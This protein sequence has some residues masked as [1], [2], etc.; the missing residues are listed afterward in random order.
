MT[1][2]VVWSVEEAI[3]AFDEHLRRV[4]GL[5]A[6]T[7]VNYARFAGAFLNGRF[8]AGGVEV[9][10]IS[11]GDVVGFVE[12]STQ[13]YQPR[14]VELAATSL[15]SL[16]RFFRS[17]GRCGVELEM[18]VPMVPHRRR[19][20]VRHLGGDEVER[21]IASL[22]ASSTRGLRDR[23]VILCVARLG[24]R[25]GEVAALRLE[26]IEWRRATVRVRAR[27]TGHGARLPLTA[28][29]GEALVDYL[30]RGRP[31]TTT[32]EVFV[33]VTGRPGA[34]ISNCIVGRAVDR[35]LTRAGIVAPTRGGNLLR[36]SLAT[37]LQARG[38]ALAEIAG[39]LGHGSL[40]TTRIYAAVDVASL[41]QVA[42]P[43]PVTA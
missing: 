11:A 21:L 6:G 28:E 43:W 24:L 8:A 30:Q 16:F 12:A 19:G 15:R 9:E 40:A 42:L 29:V 20:L 32:R 26:D 38:V 22:D 10:R 39:L 27:K 13:R 7:R 14:T 4:R 34:P 3:S 35:A 17:E 5:S 23:A 33:L 1:G 31:E 37:G 18:A 2:P 25:P 41:R 36:H